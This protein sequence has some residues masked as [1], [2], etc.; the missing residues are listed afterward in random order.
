MSHVVPQIECGQ[1]FANFGQ[2]LFLYP[3]PLLCSFTK[4][5][6]NE[7]KKRLEKLSFYI[8]LDI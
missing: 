1:A 8:L 2:F 7:T 6:K 5:P 3:I 4:F